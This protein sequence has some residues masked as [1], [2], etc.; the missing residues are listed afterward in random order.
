MKLGTTVPCKK[1]LC[2]GIVLFK[3]FD[4]LPQNT[5]YRIGAKC[6][7]C[8]SCHWFPWYLA[9]PAYLIVLPLAGVLPL[10]LLKG[11]V[12]G[13]SGMSFLLF[14]GTMLA[15]LPLACTLVGNLSYAL[16][17]HLHVR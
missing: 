12:F 10:A 2:T 6:Q 9:V 7:T 3:W 8:G 14:F 16:S 15:L 1:H 11:G 4:F 5:Y 13:D 17:G